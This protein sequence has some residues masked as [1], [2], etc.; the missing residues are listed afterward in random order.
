MESDSTSGVHRARAS[1]SRQQCHLASSTASRCVAKPLLVLQLLMP[2]SSS[3]PCASEL[4]SQPGQG[5]TAC[6]KCPAVQEQGCMRHLLIQEFIPKHL[7]LQSSAQCLCISPQVPAAATGCPEDGSVSWPGWGQGTVASGGSEGS[8]FGCWVTCKPGTSGE[9]L[10]PC[11][12]HR[13]ST[14]AL[15]VKK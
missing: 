13:G 1:L 9:S 4:S 6:P 8:Q 14:F 5:S 15:L 3:S 12:T 10:G 2:G 11:H 7:H